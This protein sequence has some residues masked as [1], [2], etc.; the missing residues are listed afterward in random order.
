[1]RRR[2]FIM[3][4]GAAVTWLFAAQAQEMPRFPTSGILFGM[5]VALLKRLDSTR[6]FSKV[7]EDLGH[8]EVRDITLGAYLR[9]EFR[10]VAIEV[11]ILLI[12]AAPPNAACSVTATMTSTLR[13]SPTTEVR[14]PS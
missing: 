8:V 11:F 5:Q 3:V 2:H 4:G 10:R 9:R 14:A 6:R 12:G 7:V 13:R 1:M